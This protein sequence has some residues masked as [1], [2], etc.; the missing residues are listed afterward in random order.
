MLFA[1][2]CFLSCLVLCA[3][4]APWNALPDHRGRDSAAALLRPHAIHGLYA[5]HP[6]LIRPSSSPAVAAR[7]TARRNGVGTDEGTVSHW[8]DFFSDVESEDE[9]ENM[10]LTF[11]ITCTFRRAAMPSSYRIPINDT[12]GSELPLHF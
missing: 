9:L 3:R 4:L 12:E 8:A 2:W 11:K 1:T 10:R 6:G 5:D 7:R